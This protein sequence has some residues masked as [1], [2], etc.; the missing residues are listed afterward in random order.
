MSTQPIAYIELQD[1]RIPGQVFRKT[2]A[3][4][5]GL[6]E[7]VTFVDLWVIFDAQKPVVLRNVHFEHCVLVFKGFTAQSPSPTIEKLGRDLLAANITDFRIS[8]GG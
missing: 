7:S 2:A 1:V 8:S 3:T 6:I 5:A 4:I